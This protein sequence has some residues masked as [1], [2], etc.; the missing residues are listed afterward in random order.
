MHD[1]ESVT[2][3]QFSQM[4]QV[5]QQSGVLETNRAGRGA[6]RILACKNRGPTQ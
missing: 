4:Q 2:T 3:L 6:L 1:S 5:R